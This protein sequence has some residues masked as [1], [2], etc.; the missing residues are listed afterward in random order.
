MKTHPLGE[1]LPNAFGLYDMHGNVWEWTEDCWNENYNGAPTDG[2]AWTKEDCSRR[3]VRGG[4]W[5]SGPRNLRSAYRNG[6]TTAGRSSFDS[7]RVAR[8][9]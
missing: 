2:R 6:G 9:D 3:V 4:S 7:F 5:G 8:T 1:K